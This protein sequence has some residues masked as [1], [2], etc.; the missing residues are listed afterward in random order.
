MMRNILLLIIGLYVMACSE[1]SILGD[2]FIGDDSFD[3]SYIDT[4]S[5]ELSTLRYDSV[6]TSTSDR[7]LLAY[8]S[9]SV[10]TGM[11][12]EGYFLLAPASDNTITDS[13]VFDSITISLPLDGYFYNLEDYVSVNVQLE[14][15][16][17]ELESRAYYNF[18][19][20]SSINSSKTTLMN[21][22]VKFYADRDQ[23]PEVR[24]DNAFGESLFN[25][26]QNGSDKIETSS[27]FY[28]YLK[29]L[30]LSITSDES[31]GIGLVADSIRLRLYYTNHTGDTE[32]QSELDMYVSGSPYFTHYSYNQP[33]RFESIVEFGDQVI[34]DNTHHASLIHGGL[35]YRTLVSLP[36]IEE[37]TLTGKNYVISGALLKLFPVESTDDLPETIYATYVTEDLEIISSSSLIV[38]LYYDDDHGRDTFFAID[39]SDLIASMFADESTRNY[40][41][42]FDLDDDLN[43][44]ISNLWIGD[45]TYRSELILYTITNK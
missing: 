12:T 25:L 39:V 35:G 10:F 23:D 41:V 32:S 7:L 21:R 8:Q 29:G 43:N 18:S 26:Y 3:L 33:Q 30:Q 19:N 4:V 17:E 5:L 13:D 1:S 44:S 34:S 11:N 14:R 27:E 6:I 38:S 42:V 16:T 20:P 9:D 15:L 37:L 36:S 2:E 31:V 22:E 28:Q 24:I 45:E 40:S